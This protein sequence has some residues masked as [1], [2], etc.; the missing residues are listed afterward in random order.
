MKSAEARLQA[1]GMFQTTAIRKSAF[2]SGSCGWGH[3][4]SQK[5]IRKSSSPSEI[6]APIC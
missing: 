3:S 6:F 2:T 1:T 4:E 5:K